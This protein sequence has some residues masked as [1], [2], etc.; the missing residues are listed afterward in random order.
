MRETQTCGRKAYLWEGNGYRW[1]N[2]AV[3]GQQSH[4]LF[5]SGHHVVR[6]CPQRFFQPAEDGRVGVLRAERHPVVAR[7]SPQ[8]NQT[9]QNTTNKKGNALYPNQ[10]VDGRV[11]QDDDPFGVGDGG[12]FRP[13]V[14]QR[15]AFRQQRRNLPAQQIAEDGQSQNGGRR[16]P[17]QP[18]TRPNF[19]QNGHQETRSDPDLSRFFF[20]YIYGELE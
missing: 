7:S 12:Q 10:L 15:L 2:A 11:F 3:A 13:R 6:I 9:K 4:H 14:Q 5:Q 19:P 20:K 17:L 18:E 16:A 8:K 1:K